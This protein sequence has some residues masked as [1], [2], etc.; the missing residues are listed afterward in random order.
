VCASST[1][2][3]LGVDVPLGC[4]HRRGVAADGACD[5]SERAISFRE[6]DVGVISSHIRVTE[7]PVRE[8]P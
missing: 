2:R 4:R 6:G 1:V 5:L 7:P 8:Q 3:G